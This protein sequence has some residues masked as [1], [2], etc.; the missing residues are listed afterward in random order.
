MVDVSLSACDRSM[1]LS[2]LNKS[3]LLQTTDFVYQPTYF[4]Y[5]IRNYLQLLKCKVC[6]KKL[7]IVNFEYDVI[8]FVLSF[9]KAFPLLGISWWVVLVQE[10]L[11]TFC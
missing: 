4:T 1:S 9:S 3:I 10:A 8:H 11:L 7:T 2:Y 5:N 6:R